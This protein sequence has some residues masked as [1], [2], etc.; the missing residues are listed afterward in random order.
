MAETPNI[1]LSKE[2]LDSHYL[3]F[4]KTYYIALDIYLTEFLTDKVRILLFQ[5]NSQLGQFSKVRVVL[6][7]VLHIR[8][9]KFL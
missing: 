6:R 5:I 8:I 9:Y 4:W 1:S 7:Q 2:E 3:S